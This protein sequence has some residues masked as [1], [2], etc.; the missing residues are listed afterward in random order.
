MPAEK[1]IDTDLSVAWH[2]AAAV[3]ACPMSCESQTSK[4][5]VP[6]ITTDFRLA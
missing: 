3:Y 5:A 4:H 6:H 1:A 2:G